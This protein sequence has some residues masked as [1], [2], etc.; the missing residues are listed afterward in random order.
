MNKHSLQIR[1]TH[2][3]DARVISLFSISTQIKV[4]LCA[5]EK[6][7]YTVPYSNPAGHVTEFQ[8]FQ[9]HT[10]NRNGWVLSR[11]GN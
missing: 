7:K 10:K 9:R 8:S 2:P 1:R 4:S 5:K 6:L 11:R 3:S